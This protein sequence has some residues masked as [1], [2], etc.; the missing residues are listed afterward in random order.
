MC[1]YSTLDGASPI[2]PG[3]TGVWEI[4]KKQKISDRDRGKEKEDRKEK[5]G[6]VTKEVGEKLGE[7]SHNSNENTED[8]AVYS[9][10][11]KKKPATRKVDVTI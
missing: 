7:K 8:Q 3:S 5:E 10:E 9:P 4:R 1:A 2:S 6:K 11:G